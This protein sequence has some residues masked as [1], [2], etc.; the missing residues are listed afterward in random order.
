MVAVL[1]IMGVLY[2]QNPEFMNSGNLLSSFFI[3][4]LVLPVVVALNGLFSSIFLA[5]SKEA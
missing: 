3:F 4:L 1:V 2:F 5:E